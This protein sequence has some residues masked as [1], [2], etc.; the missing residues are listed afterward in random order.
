[1]AE[2]RQV[3]SRRK[4]AA[5]RQTGERETDGMVTGMRAAGIDGDR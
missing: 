3:G 4:M 5:G 1:M 2:G